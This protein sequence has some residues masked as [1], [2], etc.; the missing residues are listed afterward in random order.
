VRSELVGRG[1]QVTIAV[2]GLGEVYARFH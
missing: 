1:D 2:E